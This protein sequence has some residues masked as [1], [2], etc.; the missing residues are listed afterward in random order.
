MAK[1]EGYD[2]FNQTFI[3]KWN[4]YNLETRKTTMIHYP[5][6]HVNYTHTQNTTYAIVK[7]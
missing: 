4:L 2:L 3:V 7:K 5:C 6:I 1:S